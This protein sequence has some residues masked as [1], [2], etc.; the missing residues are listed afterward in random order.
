MIYIMVP[1]SKMAVVAICFAGGIAAAACAHPVVWVAFAAISTLGMLIIARDLPRSTVLISTAMFITGAV[2]YC[3]SSEIARDDVSRYAFRAKEFEGVVASDPES[4]EERTRLVCRV[5]RVSIPTS[6]RPSPSEGERELAN[7][8]GSSGLSTLHSGLSTSEWRTASGLVMVNIYSSEP[9]LEYGDR[10]RISATPYPPRDPTNPGQFSWKD[11]L[12]RQ[13][14]YSCAYV[15]SESQVCIMRSGRG[16]IFV[17]AALKAKHCIERSIARIVPARE[18]S[19]MTGMVLGT[20]SYLPRETLANF[21]RTGTLHLLAASGYNCFI[22]LFLATPVLKRVGILPKWR[23]I[24]VILLVTMYLLM[25]GPKPSLVRASLMAALILIAPLLRRS[26]NIRT[27]FFVTGIAVLA[28]KPSYLFDIG[29][30]LSFL[31]V[32]AL[33]SIAPVVE[34]LLSRAGVLAQHSPGPIKGKSRWLRKISSELAS[35]GIA[36]ASV[37]LFTAPA[38]A[39]YFNYFSLVSLPANVALALGVPLVFAGGLL[40]P[41]VANVPILGPA[42][43]WMGATVTRAMLGIVDY[44]GSWEHSSVAVQSPGVLAIIGYYVVLYAALSYV[45]SRYAS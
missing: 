14:I 31:A 5:T 45:R 13:S 33:I 3:I 18:A 15:R 43:G 38:I 35:A 1:E 44:L 39:Y 9:K 19:V 10:V 20:Y 7:R 30:Q 17:S 34:S 36:T 37:T 8:G 26:P 23:N 16:N 12:A 21:G 2:Y 6:P 40:A 4:G 42:I 41:A 28:T 11:Y 32:W 29:F 24:V 25:V 22:L 27:L